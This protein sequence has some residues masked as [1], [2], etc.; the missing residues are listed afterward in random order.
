[1][2]IFLTFYVRTSVVPI[3]YFLT[4]HAKNRGQT[5]QNVLLS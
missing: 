5:T 1:M 3:N 4:V 2:T